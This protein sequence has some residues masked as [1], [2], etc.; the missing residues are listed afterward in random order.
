MEMVSREARA[1]KGWRRKTND[2]R[3]EDIL[4]EENTLGL[5]DEEVDEFVNVA[6]QSIE[7][8]ARH[9]VVLAGTQLRRQSLA[10]DGLASNL[11]KNRHAKRH[12]GQLEGVA[13]HIKVSGQEDDGNDAGVG[14]GRSTCDARV[15]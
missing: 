1:G 11:G 3:G 12:P 2:R 15:G 9:S 10:Q 14:D 7:G 8:L 6:N 5:D 4:G 13:D